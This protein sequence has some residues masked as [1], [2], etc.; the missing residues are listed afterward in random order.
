[1]NDTPKA[2][3]RREHVPRQERPPW[4]HCQRLSKTAKDTLL[5]PSGP[6]RVGYADLLAFSPFCL[7]AAEH[8]KTNKTNTRAGNGGVDWCWSGVMMSSMFVTWG[9]RGSLDPINPSRHRVRG[10]QGGSSNFLIGRPM[11]ER[12]DGSFCAFHYN[13]ENTWNGIHN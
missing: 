11:R 2:C 10:Q 9:G 12:L 4:S 3:C 8:D 7:F 13:Y 1:M 5:P 6:R